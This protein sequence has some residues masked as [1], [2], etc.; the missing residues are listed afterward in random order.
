MLTPSTLRRDF[1][2]DPKLKAKGKDLVRHYGCAGCHE[3]SGLEDEGRIGTELTN[4]GSKPIER[5]DFA[6]LTED[7]KRGILPDGKPSPRGSWFDAKGFFEQKLKDPGIYDT[8]KYHAN[9]LDTLRMPKPNLYGD[10]DIEALVTHA[11]RQH[12]RHSA[13]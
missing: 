3:I 4:E 13:A 6:R 5:L 11:A 12:G 10:G 1:M 8:G 2:D 9:P 7:A